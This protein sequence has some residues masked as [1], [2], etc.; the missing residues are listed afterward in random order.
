MIRY[1]LTLAEY[2]YNHVE[3]T[4][5]YISTGIEISYFSSFRYRQFVLCCYYFLCKMALRGVDLLLGEIEKAKD[6]L[7]NIDKTI[8]K[9]T[10]R[11]PNEPAP[12]YV[13]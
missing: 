3:I 5:K 13:I 4:N 6:S 9:L 7:D 11:N 12:R 10:G 1:R 2:I 8:A